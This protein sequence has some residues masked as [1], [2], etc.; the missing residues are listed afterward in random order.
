MT[1]IVGACTFC[2]TPIPV[3]ITLQPCTVHGVLT[4]HWVDDYTEARI[5]AL[6]H[7]VIA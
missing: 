1:V 7:G 3:R 5:H 2:G 4:A 6:E